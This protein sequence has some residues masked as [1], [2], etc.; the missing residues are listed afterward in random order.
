MNNLPIVQIVRSYPKKELGLAFVTGLLFTLLYTGIFLTPLIVISALYVPFIVYFLL[1]MYVVLA[2]TISYGIS[3]FLTVLQ[4]HHTEESI[5]YDTLKARASVI[6]AIIV[7]IILS[8]VY[9]QY[10]Q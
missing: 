8:I 7:F 10:L 5:Q 3:M 1:L 6:F 2:L 9:I 4:H